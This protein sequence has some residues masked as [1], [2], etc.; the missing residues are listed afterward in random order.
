M[1]RHAAS[2]LSLACALAAACTST[3]DDRPSSVSAT[4]A[5]VRPGSSTAHVRWEPWSDE[6]F[7]RAQREHRFV[8]LDLEA[9]WC[10]WCHVMEDETYSDPEVAELMADHFVAVK[11]DQDSRPDL[12]NRYEDYGWPATIV[13]AAGGGEIAKRSGFIPPREF[14][15]LL[16]AIVDDP[17]PGPSVVAPRAMAFSS[18]S[19]LGADLRGELE[20]S[21]AAAYDPKLAGFGST[22]KYLDAASV[23]YCMLRGAEGDAEHETMA[24]RTLDANLA[25]IDPAFGGVYQYSAG[26]VWTEPHFEK[27]MSM[28]ADDM[29]TYALAYALYG[30]PRYSKAAEDIH[31][32][33]RDFLTR[34]DGAFFTSQ[35][36]DLVPGEHAGEYFALGD[37]E[38]RA[39]GIPRID[40]HVYA[41]E[42]GWA[43][44]ALV[45]LYD[46]GGD[47]SALAEA[48]RSVERIVAERGLPGGGFRHDAADAAGPYLGDT[49][50][51]AQAFLALYEATGERAWL[52]R[53][54]DASRFMAGHFVDESSPAGFTTARQ[55]PDAGPLAAQAPEREENVAMARLENALFHY[56]GAKEHRA[57]A[58]RAMRY[59]ATP[60]V[61]R[62]AFTSGPLL[63]DR[64]LARDPLHVTIVGAKG[65]VRA[66]ELMRAA[67]SYPSTYRRIEWWDPAEG[68]LQNADVEYPELGKPAAF[69]CAQGRCSSPAFAPADI[70][71][72]IDALAR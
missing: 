1:H 43:A 52:A 67:I 42:N 70:H 31:R 64:E 29:R 71:A 8:V 35:D 36:A 51:M 69:A 10:H 18:A 65:D 45:W 49:L 62:V 59:V 4:A 34:S 55:R 3:S 41:R 54:E 19:A 57:R 33:L 25:L 58:E 21:L 60:E 24:R 44:R 17:T 40:E 72:R 16:R 6:A 28:Q 13:F 11:V 68:P 26:G 48:R 2:I 38:R 5:T 39:R 50:A 63:A 27:I 15:A 37:A 7:A 56:D 14:A 22:H 66:R 23:E 9:V 12:S 20:K 30:E 53:A 47:A 32:Y 61:A 46:F